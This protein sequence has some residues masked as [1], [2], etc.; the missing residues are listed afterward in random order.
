MSKD[1]WNGGAK[2]NVLSVTPESL[3]VLT[4]AISKLSRLVPAVPC[5]EVVLN[6]K[7]RTRPRVGSRYGGLGF[8]VNYIIVEKW[9][10]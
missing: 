3:S 7:C 1:S 10:M 4:F 2:S 5:P 8:V 6:Y 9:L